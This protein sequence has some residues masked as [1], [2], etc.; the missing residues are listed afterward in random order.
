MT[1]LRMTRINLLILLI[2]LTTS[3]AGAQS[4]MD[5]PNTTF[6]DSYTFPIKPGSPEWKSLNSHSEKLEV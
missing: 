6:D 4:N 2:V 5:N 3:L 1:L